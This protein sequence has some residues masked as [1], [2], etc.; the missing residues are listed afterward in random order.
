[1]T[2]KMTALEK[3]ASQKARAAK[4]SS[5]PMTLAEA[6]IAAAIAAQEAY[7]ETVLNLDMQSQVNQD[8]ADPQLFLLKS[9]LSDAMFASH[10]QKGFV[11]ER[12]AR[13]RDD[14][15]KA[16]QAQN[17]TE[18]AEVR[19]ERATSWLVRY[20]SQWEL[21]DKVFDLCQQWHK[22]T[23]GTEWRPMKAGQGQVASKKTT[24]AREQAASIMS[25]IG[26]DVEGVKAEGA[27][28]PQLRHDGTTTKSD[29]DDLVPEEAR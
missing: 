1:M 2:K 8:G 6:A 15:K 27:A 25:R 29:D 5:D 14:F 11:S 28:E 18:M 26:I 12:Y 19:L 24:A 17:G 21:N 4:S 22:E 9:V 3:T 20:Y 16:F 10:K 7:L 23:F 13:A